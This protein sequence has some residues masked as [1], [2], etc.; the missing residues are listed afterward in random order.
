[1]DNNIFKEKWQ[2]ILKSSRESYIKTIKTLT[3]NQREIEEIIKKVIKDYNIL[4]G[5][6]VEKTFKFVNES[7][8]K[9]EEFISLFKKNLYQSLEIMPN[10]EDIIFKKHF[11]DLSNLLNSFY[12][13]FFELK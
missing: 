1:M 12:Y 6:Q 7:L 5:A 13:D 10:V 11:D 4:T 2:E 8:A 3:A 9:R